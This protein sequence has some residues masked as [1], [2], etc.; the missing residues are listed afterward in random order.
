MKKITAILLTLVMMLSLMA[1]CTGGNTD[2]TQPTT[3]PTQA[4]TGSTEAPTQPTQPTQS[5]TEPTQMGTATSTS[6]QI[7]NGIW[8]GYG[9]SERFACYGGT[10]EHSV[11][12]APGD[13][14]MTNTEEITNKYLLPADQLANVESGASLVH[15]MNS[16][17]FTSAV[18]KLKDGADVRAVAKALRDNIQKTQWICGQPDHLLVAEV[19]SHLLMAFAA[20]DAMDTFRQKLNTAYAD[21]TII[22]DEAVTA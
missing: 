5:T 3:D 18:F 1:G 8:T 13:L 19:D 21:T 7:L 17:I 10:V 14:D 2:Q 15:L 22:Y 9:E 4:S 6:A 11:S 20:K 16:N 12:D